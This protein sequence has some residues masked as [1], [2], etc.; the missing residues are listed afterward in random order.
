[1]IL[2][3]EYFKNKILIKRPYLITESV[4]TKEISNGIVLDYDV[5]GQLTSIEIYNA[6]INNY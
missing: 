5:L 2:M 6:K 3:T 4:E 1:M